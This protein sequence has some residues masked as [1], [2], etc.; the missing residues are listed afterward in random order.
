MFVL[1][2]MAIAGQQQGFDDGG[3]FIHL[4][5]VYS[6]APEK[7]AEWYAP[8]PGDVGGYGIDEQAPPV[9]HLPRALPPLGRGGGCPR[10]GVLGLGGRRSQARQG[11]GRPRLRAVVRAVL[12]RE[13]DGTVDHG[14]QARLVHGGAHDRQAGR[15]S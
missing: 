15:V 2:P 6:V 12:W 13:D 11:T 9:L 7:L 1:R 4:A 3:G 14:H 5:D 8:A 10:P